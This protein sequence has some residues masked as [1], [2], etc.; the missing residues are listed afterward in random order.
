MPT[1]LT[2]IGS[3]KGGTGKTFIATTLG[4]ALARAG[5]RVLLC[6]ADVGLSNTQVHLGLAPGG[7]LVDVLFDKVSLAEAVVSV[8]GGAGSKRGFDLIA[9]PAGSGAFANLE[10]GIVERLTQKLRAAKNYDR[11]LIDLSAGVDARTMAFAKGADEVLL[12]LNSDPAALTDAYAFAKLLLTQSGRVPAMIVNMAE[13]AA[14][15]RRTAQSL[16]K[17]CRAFL[18]TEPPVLGSIPRDPKV[19]QSVRLQRLV[20]DACPGSAAV[21]AI[22]A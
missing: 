18:K 20:T 8:C 10:A 4:S 13:N 2:A 6:D 12:V 7:G 19:A 16:A 22:G 21:V 3:G 17:T 9:A 5:E 14:D 11:V 1:R 15:A